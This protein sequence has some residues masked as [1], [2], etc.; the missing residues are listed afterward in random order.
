MKLGCCMDPVNTSRLV[1]MCLLCVPIIL[2]LI[3]KTSPNNQIFA[4]YM[5]SEI[6]LKLYHS[7]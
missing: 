2:A 1:F 6:C 4:D 3:F 7:M 5:S